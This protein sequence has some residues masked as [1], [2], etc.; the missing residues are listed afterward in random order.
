MYYVWH[1]SGALAGSFATKAEAFDCLDETQAY[2]V[3]Y[4]R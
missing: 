1:Y 2:R 3:T 4:V